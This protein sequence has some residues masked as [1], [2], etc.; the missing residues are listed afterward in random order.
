MTTVHD[1]EGAPCLPCGCFSLPL[2]GRLAGAST[3]NP[4]RYIYI[5]L[6]A[7]RNEL[8][9]DNAVRKVQVLE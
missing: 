5:L 8:I 9:F 6:L 7:G 3:P 1:T 2:G 4:K